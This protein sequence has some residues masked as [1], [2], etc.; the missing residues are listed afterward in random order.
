MDHTPFKHKR[1]TLERAEKFISTIYFTDVNLRG[2]LYTE[3]TSLASIKHYAAPDRITFQQAMEENFQ[4]ANIGQSFGP[5]WSTHWFEL[6]L[7]I[8]ASWKEKEVHLLWNSGTEALVWVNGE[9]QQGLSA[10]ND[11][12]SYIISHKLDSSELHKIIYIEMACNHLFGI[13]NSALVKPEDDLK[14]FTLC[15]AEVA[16]FDRDVFNLIL[17]VETLHDIAKELPND[18]QRGYQALYTVNDMINHLN[19]ADKSTFRKAQEVAQH[20]FSQRNGQSQHTVYAMGHA[21]IDTAWLWPY[22]ETIRKC[23]RSWSCTLRLMEKYP[24]FKFTCSQAQQY[25]WVKE[26]YPSIWKDIC[27]YV[28]KGQF[29]PVG[30]TWVEMDGNIPS[31]EACI[32]QFL[33]GQQFFKQ[34][35]DVVCKEF[36]LPDTFGYSAQF[37]QIMRHCGVSRF[38]T[39]KLSWSLVN[40]FPHHT[41]HWEGLDG[42]SILAHFPPGDSY[43]MTGKVNELLKTV[44]N[45]K[46]KGRSNRSAFLFGYGDGGHGPSEDMLGRLA[47]LSDCDGLPK[48]KLSGSDEFFS[49]IEQENQ[50]MLC[51]WRG[52]LYLELHNGTYTTWAKV[53]KYNRQCEILLQELETVCTVAR[54]TTPDF[55]YPKEEIER[56]WKL[57]LLNQFHDVL[58]GSSINLVFLDAIKYYEDIEK[59]STSL[60]KKALKACIKSNVKDDSQTGNQVEVYVV[61]TQAYSRQ[62]VMNVP[63]AKLTSPI[64]KKRRVSANSIDIYAD[65][66]QLVQ[67]SIPGL[68]VLPL[69]QCIV[70]DEIKGDNKLQLLKEDDHYILSNEYVKAVIDPLGRVTSLTCYNKQTGRWSK[71]T[72]DHQHP[73]NQFLLYD[74]V[75]LYWDAWDVMDYH[76]ETRKPLLTPIQRVI[77]G[78]HSSSLRISLETSLKISDQSYLRQEIVLDADT[79][80]L[81]FNT[82]V[83]WHENRKF[84]K[85]EF[86]TTIHANEATFDIQSGHLKR[87][88]HYNT[89]WDS[90]KFE[91]CG[92]KWVDLSEYGLG[93]SILNNCKYGHSVI[94]G[95]IRLSLLRSPKSPDPKADMGVHIFSYALMPHWG[96]FQEADVIQNAISF[97]CPLQL[98]SA[99]SAQL[100]N[101][102]SQGLFT[103]DTKQVII[104][105][106]KMAEDCSSTVI[107][108]LHEA[109]GGSTQVKITSPIDLHEVH[110]CNGLEDSLQDIDREVVIAFQNLDSGCQ[111]QFDVLP[112]QIISLRCSLAH[113]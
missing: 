15:Q 53:K 103:L 79:P 6:K 71:E 90:A 8:P 73:A 58:P 107:L 62:E 93:V 11:R 27:H 76:L 52:E 44:R 78:E 3:R 34:E 60:M 81:V 45:F 49:S 17:D 39:Q 97:N 111:F 14:T 10:D 101:I 66:V 26:N 83:T 36:W 99:P 20:F 50:N 74:D 87:P 38:L 29:I 7:N 69:S 32:R 61:N 86:P 40:K 48:V 18:D 109:Y 41:F 22:A 98:I 77:K 25:S 108:R 16:L 46:D 54:V 92:H 80:Y 51:K 113:C 9:P 12:I 102:V 67:V 4:P 63:P 13:G 88:N 47:R 64:M 85:V 91:V 96:N 106:I 105:A 104:Q 37:P 95:I 21:H 75:P 110:A 35:F 24:D 42:S 2:R 55:T 94:D 68:C 56:L 70:K 28:H 57:L 1:T 19:V 89:S 100:S 43:H 33:Y 112:F 30:G 5:V 82:E 65:G 72:I 84:L 23:A 31:G 59:T